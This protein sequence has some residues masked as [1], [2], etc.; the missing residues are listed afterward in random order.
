M[1]R[2]YNVVFTLIDQVQLGFSLGPPQDENDV[3]TAPLLN[4]FDR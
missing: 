1:C 3:L 2:L 4:G